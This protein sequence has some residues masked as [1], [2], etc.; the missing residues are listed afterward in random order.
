[1]IRNRDA[2]QRLERAILRK[3]KPNLAKNLRLI[4]ALYKEAVSLGVFPPRDELLGIEVDMRIAKAVN[5][6]SKSPQ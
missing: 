3:E 5:S 1:M 2:V 6:V 4:E